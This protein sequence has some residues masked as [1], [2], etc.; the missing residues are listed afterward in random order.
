MT[1][2]NFSEYI[3]LTIYDVDAFQAYDD[4]IQYARDAVPEF[5]PRAGTLE[6]AIMQAIAYNTSLIST[7]I[8]RLPD[9]LME[10]IARLAGL[11]RRE[12]TFALGQAIF[13]VFDD[14]GVTIP[15]GTVV[16]YETIN[17]D[18]ITSYPFETLGDLII[19]EGFTTGSVT[20]QATEAGVY[21][22]LLGGQALELVSPAP[23]VI[24]VETESAIFVGSDSETDVDYFNR[25]AQHFSSLSSS[26]TTKTQILN[27]VRANYPFVGALAVFDLTDS[28]GTLIWG[29]PP[30]PGY[31]TIV[32]SDVAGNALV[33]DQSN[34]VLDDVS[35]KTVA[36]LIV[37]AVSPATA[38]LVCNPQ[39]VV[40]Q[41]FAASEVR[42][43]VDA[44]LQKRL[45][46]VGYDFSGKIVRNELIAEISNIPGV[47]YVNELI[48]DTVSPDLSLDP[49]NG[50]L[51]FT[52]I[53]GTPLASIEVTSV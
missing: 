51:I 20:I 1:S 26:L 36:G 47:R 4:A 39:I 49:V 27:Y 52:Y 53:N 18:I 50:D 34:L 8:N 24:S 25:A 44:Y 21:P 33:T 12:A 29:D 16:A 19:P 30:T 13:E 14:N 9:G 32:L 35:S 7:Q 22:A 41:G 48:L 46:T 31:V 17:D 40:S 3:D 11:E 43:A 10:G 37:G 42:A 2:P 6:E 5:Q 45:S 28:S 38:E 15:A 23:G